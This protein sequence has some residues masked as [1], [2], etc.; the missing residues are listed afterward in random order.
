[1]SYEDLL[2]AGRIRAEAIADD[3]IRHAL[4]SDWDWG[5]SIAYD[6]V[7]QAS[8]AYMFAQRYRPATSEGHKNTLAFMREAM[9]RDYADLISYFDRMRNKRIRPSTMS[10][11]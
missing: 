11:D 3:E 4:A 6:A 1:M 5:F 2:K 10:P 9:G 8:R 7:L